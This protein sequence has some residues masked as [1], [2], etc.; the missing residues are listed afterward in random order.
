MYRVIEE[1]PLE[2][3]PLGLD[4]TRITGEIKGT[5][6]MS[7]ADCCIAALAKHRK[8]TI[9]HK[10]PEYEQI[11]NEVKQYILPYKIM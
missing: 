9:I 4:L 8:A 2:Q 6:S 10:D 1:L 3:Q 7:F 11:K 5:K